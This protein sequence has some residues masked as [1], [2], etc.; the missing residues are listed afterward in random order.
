MSIRGSM[1]AHFYRDELPLMRELGLNTDSSRLRHAEYVDLGTVVE[2]NDEAGEGELWRIRVEVECWPSK[3]FRFTITPG[4]GDGKPCILE[5]GSGSLT[6]F[7]PVAHLFA[8]GMVSYTPLS[9]P[10]SD[11]ERGKT[12]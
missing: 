4:E 2:L 8:E 6:T 7:W 12:T 9:I 10:A 5:T 1:D 11:T 3:F